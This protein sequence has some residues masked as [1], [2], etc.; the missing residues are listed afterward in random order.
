MNPLPMQVAA[1]TAPPTGQ[2][3]VEDDLRDEA[4]SY[5]FRPEQQAVTTPTTGGVNNIVQYVSTA[6]GDR[7]VLRIYN[8]GNKTEKVGFTPHYTTTPHHTI[9]MQVLSPG[10]A[11]A[12]QLLA[13][14]HHCT[15]LYRAQQC[16]HACTSSCM[17]VPQCVLPHLHSGGHRARHPGPAGAA[18]AQLQGPHSTASP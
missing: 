7:Y 16:V 14:A 8:N 17:Q 4:L 18:K 3:T 13:A 10:D 1:A 2:H 11:P 12:K 15:Q 9:I 5:F 6:D